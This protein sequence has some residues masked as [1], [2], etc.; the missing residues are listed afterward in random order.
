MDNEVFNFQCQLCN[1]TKTSSTFHPHLKGTQHQHNVQTEAANNKAKYGRSHKQPYYL[2]PTCNISS[3]LDNMLGHCQTQSGCS[4]LLC[5]PCGVEIHPDQHNSHCLSESHVKQTAQFSNSAELARHLGDFKYGCD[6]C[7]FLF[8]NFRKM[9]KHTNCP[10]LKFRCNKCDLSFSPDN[11]QMH[12][13]SPLHTG[14]QASINET[15]SQ[16]VDDSVV[17][18]CPSEP[19]IMEIET[20]QKQPLRDSIRTRPR[21]P[22]SVAGKSGVRDTVQRPGLVSQPSTI[23]GQNQSQLSTANKKFI[24]AC[25]SCQKVFSDPAKI[26]IHAD[27]DDKTH[28]GV[29]KKMICLVCP[30]NITD[31]KVSRQV[32][33]HLASI[34][35]KLNV[36]NRVNVLNY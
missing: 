14:K 13:S 30:W 10:M 7:S 29:P 4:N 9:S 19:S 31:S 6:S 24:F 5:V 16:P 28:P 34:Q 32:S 1:V 20:I 36:E 27:R 11:F 33:E 22:I 26:Q 12:L 23:V 17:E 3:S 21:P 2:C 18:V 25:K 8:S 15:T 35:H